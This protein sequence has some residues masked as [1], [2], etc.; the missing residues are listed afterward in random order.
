MK[1]FLVRY[2]SVSPLLSWKK[3]SE[4]AA[5]SSE[6]GRHTA[7]NIR[8]WTRAYIRNRDDLPYNMYGTWKL[9]LLKNGDLA[10][11]LHEHL[12]SI[13]KYVRAIDIVHYLERPDVQERFNLKQSI[14]LAT[15]Q[16]WMLSMNFRWGKTPRG[17]FVDGH[18]RPDVVWYRQE[19]FLPAIEVLAQ[20]ASIWNDGISE[21]SGDAPDPNAH[22]TFWFHDESTYYQNDRRNISWHHA[23]ETPT[24]HPK[25]QGPSLMVADLVSAEHG[26][27]RDGSGT[28]AGEARVYFRA[29]KDKEG[30]FTS[31]DILAQA[32]K[33]MDICE[34]T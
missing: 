30:Y 29:G 11:E 34:R 16:R 4:D 8:K 1:V 9:S 20:N 15:A 3:A 33:A 10:K 27:C 32:D 12:Q 24:P 5:V 22:T 17:M 19:R 31:E 6:K 7:E 18:E 2:T 28:P 14:S 26:Y 21:M 13:G 25:N 23:D